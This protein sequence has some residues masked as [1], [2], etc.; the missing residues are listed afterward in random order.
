MTRLICI[1]LTLLFALSGPAMG[2]YSNFGRSSLAARTL[3]NPY[4]G[5][6]D[7][8]AYLRAQGVSRADRVQILQSF[9]PQNMSVRQAGSSEFGL[10]FFS[11][12]SRAGG[13]YL[14]ETF[15]ASRSSLAIKP[16]WST[17][18][19]FKQFQV[20]P[21]ATILEGTAAPQGPFL[22]G[23]QTQKFILDWRTNLLEP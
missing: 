19:G 15:P 20:R 16:E 11:D 10:R 7:A 23:G 22:P 17:M 14:F 2:E 9:N 1:L 5:I 3:P 8:S 4:T 13:S 18:T 6:Q 21:G 12:A